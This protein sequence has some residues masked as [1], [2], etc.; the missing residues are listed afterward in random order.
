MRVAMLGQYP[1]DE[2]RIVGGVEAVMVPLLRS[3][4]SF[5]DL[6]LHVVTCQPGSG[7]E[8]RRTSAGLPL[9]IRQRRRFG[10]VTFHMRDVTGLRRTLER[11]G[12]DLVH[13]QGTGL[14]TLAALGAPCPHLVTVHGLTFR[15]AAAASS[16]PIEMGNGQN[17]FG[18]ARGVLDSYYE[19]YALA[20][21]KH[22]VSIS[23]YV[24]REIQ[25]ISDAFPSFAFRGRVFRIENPVDDRFF[26]V[27]DPISQST[28]VYVGRVIPRKGLLELLRVFELVR[29]G[30]PS[31]GLRVA[32]EV[33]AAPDYYAACRRFISEHNL[34]EAVTFLG[35]LSMDQVA[36]EYQN[37]ALVAIPSLQETSPVAVAEAMAA[38][39]PVV[40]NRVCGMPYMVE[41]G[42]S[43]ILLDYGDTAAWA[44]AL[45]GLLMDPERQ[46]R[47]GSRGRLLA[48]TRFR[49]LAVA[50]A[51][52]AAYYEITGGSTNV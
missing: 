11:I 39:R 50:R 44:S 19:R 15:E 22:L 30:I 40:T 29:R 42:Q 49:S 16:N 36:S 20:R 6:E 21:V 31:A 26:T 33:D 24:E 12:P 27:G 17:P 47:M 18:R 46:R 13:A 38:G 25:S 52:R 1:L 9:H 23:P 43:G 41:E 2:S 3:L 14:Y 37:A 45:A 48:E 32:G 51:T 35:S 10:R 34:D 7:T 5:P 8:E 4:Q 28:I